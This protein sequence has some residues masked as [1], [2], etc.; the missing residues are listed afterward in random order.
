MRNNKKL[1]YEEYNKIKNDTNNDVKI[2]ELTQKLLDITGYIVQDTGTI[3]EFEIDNPYGIDKGYYG[4]VI[5][6]IQAL[7]K[8]QAFPLQDILVKYDI[9]T[10]LSYKVT[11]LIQKI[12]NKIKNKNIS[13]DGFTVTITNKGIKETIYRKKLRNNI[14]LLKQYLYVYDNIEQILE[15]SVVTTENVLSYHNEIDTTYDTRLTIIEIGNETYSVISTIKKAPSLD[16]L[17]LTSVELFKIN[18]KEDTTS[19][20]IDNSTSLPTWSVSSNDSIN[21]KIEIV[22]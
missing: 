21:D 3:F 16:S 10:N 18:K 12:Q 4:D 1:I 20:L 9:D 7:E 6:Q 5:Q 2:K 22:K 17:H 14:E 11:T 8:T 15:N 13:F 19:G